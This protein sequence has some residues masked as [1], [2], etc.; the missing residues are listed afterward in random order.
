MT[1][2]TPTPQEQNLPASPA[3]ETRNADA[4]T[5]TPERD[6]F[7]KRVRRELKPEPI[8]PTEEAEIVIMEESD[9]Q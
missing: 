2:P 9:D 3:Q 1:E 8:H 6:G 5:S 7:F 4:N